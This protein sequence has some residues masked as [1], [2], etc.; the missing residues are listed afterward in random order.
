VILGGGRRLGVV[1][2]GGNTVILGENSVLDITVANDVLTGV[3][4]TGH[5][6]FYLG[7]GNTLINRGMITSS[8]LPAWGIVNGSGNA[9]NEGSASNEYKRQH[10]LDGIFLGRPTDTSL[11][12]SK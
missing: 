11:A 1:G 10:V 4:Q 2:G 3:S 6:V 9:L 5:S 7:E 12:R 8:V